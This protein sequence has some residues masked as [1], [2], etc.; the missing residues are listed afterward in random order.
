MRIYSLILPLVCYLLP[1]LPEYEKERGMSHYVS[2]TMET[3]FATSSGSLWWGDTL[4][5][6]F[7]SLTCFFSSFDHHNKESRRH[8][9]FFLKLVILCLCVCP[10]VTA[11]IWKV[12]GQLASIDFFLSI[13][14]VS[15]MEFRSASLAEAAFTAEPKLLQVKIWTLFNIPIPI[16]ISTHRDTSPLQIHA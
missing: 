4:S 12:R 10:H 7:P 11:C 6:V 8:K 9:D 15:G 16:E 13:V 2:T 14:W 3:A 1:V 5:K